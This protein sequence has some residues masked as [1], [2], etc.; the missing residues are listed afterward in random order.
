MTKKIRGVRLGSYVCVAEG[1]YT[2]SFGTV[3]SK[4]LFHNL[5]VAMIQFDS[6]DSARVPMRDLRLIPRRDNK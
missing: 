3:K 6:G 5:Y 2:G 4:E 1:P